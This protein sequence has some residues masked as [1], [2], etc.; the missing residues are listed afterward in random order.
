MEDLDKELGPTVEAL[1]RQ[2]KLEGLRN[3]LTERLNQVKAGTHYSDRETGEDLQEWGLHLMKLGHEFKKAD[4][5]R[6]V[7]AEMALCIEELGLN[8]EVPEL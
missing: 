3:A 2:M 7:Q 1:E 8:V 5:L 6:G 4:A